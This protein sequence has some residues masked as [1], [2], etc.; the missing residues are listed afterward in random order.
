MHGPTGDALGFF[1][2]GTCSEAQESD[3]ARVVVRAGIALLEELG[4]LIQGEEGQFD[5]IGPD[6]PDVGQWVCLVP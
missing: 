4:D 6:V 1:P 5:L 3:R 2:A